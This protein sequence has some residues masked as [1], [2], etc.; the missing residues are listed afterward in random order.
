MRGPGTTITDM[1]G[2][3]HDGTIDPW[4][5][6][7]VNWTDNGYE[8]SALEYTATTGA[9]YSFVDA[10]LTPGLLNIEESTYAFW[11]NVPINHRSWGP[12]LVLIGENHDSDFELTDTGVPYVFGKPDTEGVAYNEWA[13]ASGITLNDNQ[14]HHV[15]VTHSASNQI[16]VFY[17]DGE[18]VIDNPG[19]SF[20]DPIEVV[21]IGG[22][23]KEGRRQWASFTGI[24]DEVTVYNEAISADAVEVLAL[25]GP[26]LLPEAINPKPRDGQGDVYRDV[27]LSWKPG[28]YADKHDVYFGTD[29][30][31]V[32][33][34]S[35]DDPLDALVSQN[36]DDLTYDPPGLL[37]YGQ[38]YYWRV[39]E[40]ND[41]EPNSPWKG[42]IWSFTVANFVVVDDFEIYDAGENQIW[43]TWKDGFGYGIP[44]TADYYPGNGTGSAVGDENNPTYMETSNVHTGSQSC[45]FMYNNTS[46][47]F[48]SEIQREWEAPQ[49]W[50]SDDIVTLSL[51]FYGNADN[52]AD[53]LYV[54]VEDSAGA[55]K[56]VT[57]TD[58]A[59]VQ[60]ANWQQWDVA[61]SQFSDAGVD[62]AAIKTMY[63]GV[64]NKAAPQMGG[65]GFMLVDDIRLYRP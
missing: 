3:G 25:I 44:G 34:A 51:W 55:I 1:S 19:W 7:L 35:I 59:A 18:E 10:P 15:A 40:V 57:H 62:L 4:D 11:M 12:A 8:G 37:D 56:V 63:I 47:P 2:F 53:L 61:L 28:L 22:P 50:T 6:S 54:T 43:Y 36:Q 5:P 27:V 41:A 17:L 13:M 65:L 58:A 21:R 52:P 64:G 38:T 23:R 48:Y 24:V 31:D 42:R 39:D 16:T 33:E 32:N 45:P 46:A 14:W 20:S 49:D 30:N 60:V 26:K 9:P 29:I